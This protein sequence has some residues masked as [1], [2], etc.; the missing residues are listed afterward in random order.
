MSSLIH[1]EHI[2]FTYGQ[3]HI[4]DDVS[5]DIQMGD[6]VGIIGPNGSGKTTLLRILL[7]LLKPKTGVV[8][9]MGE[10]V[11]LGKHAAQIGYIPQKVTQLETRFPITV[12]EVVALGRVNTKKLFSRLETKDQQ[13]VTKALETV[14][15]LPFRKRLI[16]DLSGGQQ[17]RA[18]IAKALAGEPKILLLDEPTVG[19]DTESQE[20]F[21]KLLEELNRK[22]N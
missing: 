12:E 13:I 5:F 10:P 11:Q 20:N 4:L 14:E 9:V 21:Y 6:F 7:G 22:H 19:I 17:Q 18:F 16:T 1:T 2:S 15:L 3:E 8:E